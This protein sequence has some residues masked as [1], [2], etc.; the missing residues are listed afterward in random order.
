MFSL[1]GDGAVSKVTNSKSP[2]LRSSLNW[3]RLTRICV[4][5]ICY[6]QAKTR[7]VI[8]IKFPQTHLSAAVYA[9]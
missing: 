6:D 7:S 3:S 8:E 2:P 5:E 1:K 9:E 4:V